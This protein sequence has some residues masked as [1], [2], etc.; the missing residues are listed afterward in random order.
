MQETDFIGSLFFFRGLER[1]IVG[2]LLGHTAPEIRDYGRGETIFSPEEFEH[3]LG[4]VVSGCCE[5]LR[6]RPDGSTLPLNRLESGDSFGVLSLFSREETFPTA[7]KASRSCRILFFSKTDVLSLIQKEPAIAMNVI[8]F[9]SDRIGFLNKKIA[10]LTGGSAEERL[11]AYL[12]EEY[13]LRGAEL[14]VNCKKTADALNLGRA[15]LYRAMNSLTEKGFIN[16]DT[17]KI[18]IIDPQGLERK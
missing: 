16:Y 15:S 7:V 11:S 9:L 18:Y 14:S 8:E 1:S 5:V 4:F 10:T 6:V 13:R 3:K 2:E 17:K 12:L